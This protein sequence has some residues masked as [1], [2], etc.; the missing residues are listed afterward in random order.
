V[1]DTTGA[2][3]QFSFGGGG[4]FILDGPDNGYN[5]GLTASPDGGNFIAFDGE[6]INGENQNGSGALSQM[7]NGLTPGQSTTV[8]FYFAGAQAYNYPGATTEQ[9]AVSLEAR[10]LIPPCLTMRM[11]VL[12]DGTRRI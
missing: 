1:A 2:P 12:Q 5:N 4:N 8:S 7:V 10:P 6:N 3:D 9:L 11:A